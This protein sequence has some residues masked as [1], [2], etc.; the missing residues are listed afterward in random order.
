M[1]SYS[2]MSPEISEF[3][4]LYWLFNLPINYS[5][6]YGTVDRPRHPP[7]GIFKR[8]T[9]TMNVGVELRTFELTVQLITAELH[10]L[11]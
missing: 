11:F 4:F 9:H 6:Y 10:H 8:V 7:A 5:G 2:D 3:F 1:F